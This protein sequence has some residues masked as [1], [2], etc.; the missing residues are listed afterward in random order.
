MPLF[1]ETG[2]SETSRNRKNYSSNIEQNEKSSLNMNWTNTRVAFKMMFLLTWSRAFT[3]D[4]I[5]MSKPLLKLS[6]VNIKKQQVCFRWVNITPS[7]N[8]TKD[9]IFMSAYCAY[10]TN[11]PIYLALVPSPF[12]NRATQFIFLNIS[13]FFVFWLRFC[14][15]FILFFTGCFAFNF[16]FVLLRFNLIFCQLW[17]SL[18]CRATVFFRRVN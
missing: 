2:Q 7:I 5:N 1:P 13:F 10:S 12:T 17:L 4:K 11:I 14:F 15:V 6:N 16:L 3:Y 18:L 8:N 9:K